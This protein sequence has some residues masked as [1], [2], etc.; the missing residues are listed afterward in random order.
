[1]TTLDLNEMPNADSYLNIFHLLQGRVSEVFVLGSVLDPRI[2]V[3]RAKNYKGEYLGGEPMYLIDGFPV[4]KE[5]ILN[6]PIVHVESV[7]VMRGLISIIRKPGITSKF[8]RRTGVINL[9]NVGYYVSR[10]FFSPDY[11][12]DKEA[13]AKPD[14]RST[15]YWNPE[16]QIDSTGTAE[17]SFYNADYL[18]NYMVEIEGITSEGIPMVGSAQFDSK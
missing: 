14:F 11:S 2:I 18:T 17:V 6:I 15:L 10:E 5:Q 7:G 12:T 1:M 16:F 13:H 9:T 4:G 8:Q 3:G